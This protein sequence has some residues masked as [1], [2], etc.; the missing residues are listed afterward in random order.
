M[1][2]YVIRIKNDKMSEAAADHLRMTSENVKNDFQIEKFD[3]IVPHLVKK[4]IRTLLLKWTYP[5]THEGGRYDLA[6][7]LWLEPYPTVTP[8]KRMACFVSHYMLWRDCY[9]SNEPMIICEHDAEFTRKLDLDLLA[10]SK[11]GII[12]LNDPRGA[13]KKSQKYYDLVKE[14]TDSI[15]PVPKIEDMKNPQ[16]L[17]GNSAYYITPKSAKYLI[18][19]TKQYGA[20]PNDA[21]MCQQLMPKQLGILRNFVTKVQGLSSS[22]TL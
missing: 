18:D 20:W 22:T 6:S 2:A 4:S 13:T 1:K 15:V 10:S 7:G 19:L 14:S 3:A 8:I 17:P 16:G 12:A 9:D 5:W 11:Y 21:L